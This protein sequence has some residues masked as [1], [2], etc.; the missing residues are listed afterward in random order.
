MP[1]GTAISVE[2]TLNQAAYVYLVNAQGYQ[3][4]LEGKEF[5]YN[6][7]YVSSSPY[8]IPIRSSNHWYVIVDNGENA[9]T[10][11]TANVKVKSGY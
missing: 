3:N 2:V 1:M 6:G 10:G 11:I 7:G 4:Y 5:S 8:R 9:I